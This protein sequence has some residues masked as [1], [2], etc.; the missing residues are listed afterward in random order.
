MFFFKDE[1]ETVLIIFH[2]FLINKLLLNCDNNQ[3]SIV[4]HKSLKIYV[5]HSTHIDFLC[6]ITSNKKKWLTFI[7]S[8]FVYMKCHAEIKLMLSFALS[9]GRGSAI[10]LTFVAFPIF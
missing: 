3:I 9:N 7:L 10:N 4:Q 6:V 2:Q 5:D 8:H 1:L